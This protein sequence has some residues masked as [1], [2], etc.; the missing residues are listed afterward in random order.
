MKLSK[1][2]LEILQNFSAINDQ[3]AFLEGSTLR[4]MSEAR[5]ILAEAPISE[6]IDSSF[7]VSNLREFLSVVSLVDD[8]DIQVTENELKL[9][10]PNATA[11]YFP[12]SIEHINTPTKAPTMPTADLNLV[13]TADQLANIRKGCGVL[14]VSNIAITGDDGRVVLRAYNPKNPTSNEFAV[15]I[16]DDNSNTD[17][18]NFIVEV[19]SLKLMN[20]DYDVSIS[21]KLISQFKAKDSDLTYWIALEKTSTYG[22]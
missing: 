9:V 8:C 20:T 14:G 1:E 21:S 15:V 19:S 7:G 18:F 16:D 2:T 22:A 17:T 11:K 3:I 13:I 10:G 5:N 6:T 12:W 4:T